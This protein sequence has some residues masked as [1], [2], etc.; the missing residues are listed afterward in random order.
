M[1]RTLST[2]GIR[3][4]TKQK[5]KEIELVRLFGFGWFDTGETIQVQIMKMRGR[6]PTNVRGRLCFV[7]VV[8]NLLGSRQVRTYYS[9]PYHRFESQPFLRPNWLNSVLIFFWPI[10]HPSKRQLNHAS[11]L[12]FCKGGCTTYRSLE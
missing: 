10:T 1:P 2:F 3:S 9:N 6:I 4:E 11:A 7:H 8:P 5:K 12:C